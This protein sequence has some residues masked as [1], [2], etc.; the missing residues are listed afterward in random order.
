MEQFLAEQKG[1]KVG[2]APASMTGT[3]IAGAR[4]N[5][6][7]LKRVAIVCQFAASAAAVLT[8]SLKQHNAASGGTTKELE[9]T[10]A[11]YHKVGSDTKFTKVDVSV[12]ED[13]YDLSAIVANNVGIVV[14]EVLEEDLDVN[15]NFSHVSVNLVGDATAR[16]I[17]VSYICEA[18]YKPAY[19]LDL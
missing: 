16:I 3:P 10:N 4:I 15:N 9:V 19:A 13:E 2:A 8:A 7:E 12:A 17:A 1:I 11:Y 5:M 6:K 14:F 18:D